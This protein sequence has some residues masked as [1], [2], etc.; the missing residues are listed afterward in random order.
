MRN[1]VAGNSDCSEQDIECAA[2]LEADH[3]LCTTSEEEEAAR[4]ESD[5][6]EN[7]QNEHRGGD[8]CLTDDM[9]ILTLEERH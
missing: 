6:E 3:D 7:E 8:E 4:D 9:K 2:D 1:A 5:H